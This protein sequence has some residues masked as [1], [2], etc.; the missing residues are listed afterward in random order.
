MLTPT[1]S[2]PPT[3]WV[4]TG[5]QRSISAVKMWNA[6][7]GAAVTTVSL[8]I[9]AARSV[10]TG[11]LLDVRGEPIERLVPPRVDPGAQLAQPVPID[12]IDVAGPPCLVAH[13]R[14]G[15]QHPQVARHRGA[16]DRQPSCQLPTGIGS[17]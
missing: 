12:A 11:G 13:Q 6:S 2:T 7:S 1:T 16:A 3:E 10:L 5:H 4:S 8:R 15:A 14:R 9:G 17:W